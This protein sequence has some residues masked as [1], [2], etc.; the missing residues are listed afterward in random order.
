MCG[1]QACCE[2]GYHIEGPELQIFYLN[3]RRSTRRR[4]CGVLFMSDVS[5]LFVH[6]CRQTL[7]Q[8]MAK[9]EHCVGQ[10]PEQDV[11]WRPFPQANAVGNILLHLSGNLRQW[12]V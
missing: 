6:E 9:I 8:A 7:A 2:F 4:I 1:S 12:V 5:S 11:W 10:L 3:P